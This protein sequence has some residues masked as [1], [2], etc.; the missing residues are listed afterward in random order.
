MPTQD[1]A[2][3]SVC[4]MICKSLHALGELNNEHLLPTKQISDD[5]T[6]DSDTELKVKKGTRKSCALFHRKVRTISM[7]L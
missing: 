4:M 1:L 3:K 5:N 2:K 6:S 7:C